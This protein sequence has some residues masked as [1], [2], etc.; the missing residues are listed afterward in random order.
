MKHLRKFVTQG[1]TRFKAHGAKSYSYQRLTGDIGDVRLLQ[2]HPGA[3]EDPI[4]C[5]LRNVQLFFSDDQDFETVSYCWGD[6]KESSMILV[7]NASLR[8]P[9]SAEQAL[10]RFRKTNE[11]RL[12]WI[13]SVCINQSDLEER[14]QQVELMSRIYSSGTRNLIWLGEDDGTTQA[15]MNALDDLMEHI[16]QATND[17]ETFPWSGLYDAHWQTH[18]RSGIPANIDPKIIAQLC[19]KPWFSRLWV[20][21]PIHLYPQY[22][23][24]R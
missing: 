1:K 5:T 12:L 19:A 22:R 17:Y 21:R 24:S 18:I 3:P 11:V 15:A 8:V 6:T 13:D 4:E 10:H 9:K 23:R 16:R 14:A 7:N 20:G 2:L